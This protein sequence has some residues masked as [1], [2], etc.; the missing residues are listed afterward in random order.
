MFILASFP[1]LLLSFCP[2][3]SSV[4]PDHSSLLLHVKTYVS[5]MRSLSC[6]LATLQGN[7][8]EAGILNTSFLSTSPPGNTSA[9]PPSLCFTPHPHFRL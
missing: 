8:E 4:S 6:Q 3:L 2:S 1:S 5:D 7:G 9:P